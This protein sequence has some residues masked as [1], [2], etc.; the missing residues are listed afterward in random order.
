MQA[1]NLTV[2]IGRILPSGQRIESERRQGL[3]LRHYSE[4]KEGTMVARPP[5]AVECGL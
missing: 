1:L 5:N 3:S 2:G 4:L